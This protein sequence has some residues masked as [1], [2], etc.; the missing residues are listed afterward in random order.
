MVE[1]Q[2]VGGYISSGHLAWRTR[3]VGL[4][5]FSWMRESVIVPITTV[6]IYVVATLFSHLVIIVFAFV[7]SFFLSCNHNKFL[8]CLPAPL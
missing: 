5:H 4:I 2:R 6:T 1:W 8:L 3:T 7:H